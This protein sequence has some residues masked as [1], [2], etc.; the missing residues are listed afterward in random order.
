MRFGKQRLSARLVTS[1]VVVYCQAAVLALV[2]ITLLEILLVGGSSSGLSFPGVFTNTPVSGNGAL[3]AAVGFIALAVALIAVE[4]Q[5]AAGGGARRTLAVTEV[6][7]AVCFVGFVAND[8]GGWL[9]GPAA[10]LVIVGLHYWPE[11]KA[12]FFADDV[13]AK[14]GDGGGPANATGVTASPA[15]VPPGVAATVP[16]S[17]VATPFPTP[18]PPFAAPVPPFTTP[19]PVATPHASPFA[20]PAFPEPPGPNAGAASRETAP[21]HL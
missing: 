10:A 18:T 9:F 14:A 6:A 20:S 15:P 7:F 11:L 8:P 5:G 2:A 21:P 4:Q 3:I 13:A 17:T 12:Y 1:R 19:V 16:E